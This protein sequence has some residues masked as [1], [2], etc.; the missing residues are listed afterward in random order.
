VSGPSGATAGPGETFWQNPKHFC[1]EI[2]WISFQNG[3][4]WCT[5]YFWATAGPPNVGRPGVAYPLNH[6]LD[7]PG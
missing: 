3:A 7:G 6:P 1:K 5:L 2:F 4:F